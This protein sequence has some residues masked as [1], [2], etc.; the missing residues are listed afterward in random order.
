MKEKERLEI[1]F[2]RILCIVMEGETQ[3]YLQVQAELCW[4][5]SLPFLWFSGE[6][7]NGV[8]IWLYSAINVTVFIGTVQHQKDNLCVKY[9]SF[10]IPGESEF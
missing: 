10:I 6:V 1:S 5:S 8:W 2:Q 7:L 4:S 3:M 9:F